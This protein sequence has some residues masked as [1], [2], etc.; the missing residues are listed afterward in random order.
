MIDVTEFILMLL[1]KA[2]KF[3]MCIYILFI[4]YIELIFSES[5]GKF[6][7]SL[8]ITVLKADGNYLSGYNFQHY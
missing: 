4:S 2:A 3:I 1:I 6:Q 8:I 5:T 7:S